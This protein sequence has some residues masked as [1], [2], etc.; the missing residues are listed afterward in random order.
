M[1]TIKLNKEKLA[2]PPVLPEG[3]YTIRLD[4]F[5]PKKPSAKAKNQSAI[6]LRP[7]LKIINHPTYNDQ[8]VFENLSTSADWVIKD[9]VHAFGLELDGADKDELPG[10]FNPPNETDPEK[11]SYAGPLQG[12]TAQIFLKVG[13]DDKGRPQNKINQYVC[14]VPGCSDKHST[15]LGK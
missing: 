3:L 1:A 12:R 4:G 15:N 2:G 6:N 8:L 9:F 7:T 10:T 13:E 14:A 5:K 11:W